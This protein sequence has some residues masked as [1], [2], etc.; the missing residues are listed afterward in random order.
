MG[1]SNKH[2]RVF[3]PPPFSPLLFSSDHGTNLDARRAGN[4]KQSS[5][6]DNPFPPPLPFRAGC[7]KLERVSVIIQRAG[8][9]PSSPFPPLSFIGAERQ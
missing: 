3:S 7:D 5:Y 4:K 1:I 9:L 2:V 6:D 8:L